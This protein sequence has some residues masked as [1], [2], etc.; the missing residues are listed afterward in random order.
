VSEQTALEALG[1]MI[2][3]HRSLHRLYPSTSAC[4][5]GIGGQAMTQHCGVDCEN[6]A[7]HREDLEKIGRA[8]QTYLRLSGGP[9]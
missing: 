4:T 6:E 2:A 8:E 1:E 9:R 5:G 7:K 3:A